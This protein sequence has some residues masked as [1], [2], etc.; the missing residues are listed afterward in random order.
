MKQIISPPFLPSEKILKP[1]LVWIFENVSKLIPDCRAYLVTIQINKNDSKNK[2]YS[3]FFDFTRS[4]QR[5]TIFKDFWN[6]WLNYIVI[7]IF[8]D[9]PNIE[10]SIDSIVSFSFYSSPKIASFSAILPLAKQT[11]NFFRPTRTLITKSI[12]QQTHL[13]VSTFISSTFGKYLHKYGV[14]GV[15][16]HSR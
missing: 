10:G 5:W 6:F 4:K 13:S 14:V 9:L 16:Q 15:K 7:R 11:S 2:H 3:T 1:N 12:N 8:V